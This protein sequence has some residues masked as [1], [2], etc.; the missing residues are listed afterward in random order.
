MSPPSPQAIYLPSGDNAMQP[1]ENRRTI[2]PVLRFQTITPSSVQASSTV[3]INALSGENAIWWG[4]AGSKFLVA[5]TSRRRTS[6]PVFASQI[7]A[8]PSH[9]VVATHWPSG[10]YATDVRRSLWPSSEWTGFD[11]SSGGTAAGSGLALV[12]AGAGGASGNG[13]VDAAKIPAANPA[14]TVAVATIILVLD[15]VIP[16]TP[17]ASC[18]T[19][20]GTPAPCRPSTRPTNPGG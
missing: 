14:T 11:V 19:A 10:E 1:P 13:P 17:L 8:V 16:N 4:R 6:F 7:R 2:S 9:A 5:G 12:G 3:T 18:S 20:G 15:V